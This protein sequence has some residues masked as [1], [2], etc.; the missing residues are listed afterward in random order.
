MLCPA[1]IDRW[2]AEAINTVFAVAI[3]R[4]RGSRTASAAVGQT[5]VFLD[6]DG[7]TAAAAQAA[8]RRTMLD[9]DTHADA[10]AAVGHAAERA[11]TE[12]AAIK[13]RLHQLRDTA[14]GYH[15]S[16]DDRTGV[17]SLP[18][19]L[20]SFSPAA[21]REIAAAQ[22]RLLPAIRQ[23]LC[24]AEQADQD[25]A[26]A[27]RGADGDLAPGKVWAEIC[28]GPFVAP[29]VPTPDAAPEQVNAWWDSLTPSE[30]DRIKHW[31]PDAVRNRDGIPADVRSELNRAALIR[32]LNRLHS[33]WLDRNGWHTE[34]GKLADLIA[35][36]DC[37][38]GQADTDTRLLLLDTGSHPDKV[39][40]AVAVGDVD[41]AERVGVTVAG[42][43]SRVSASVATMVG[44]A[45]NQR[46]AAAQ[47]RRDAALGQPDA[48]AAV[49]YL[50]YDAPD[51]VNEVVRDDLARAGAQPLNRFYRGL[52]AASNVAGAHLTAFGHS[53]GS[54]T[55]SLALQ[56]GAPVGDV[57]LYGSPGAAITDAT[58]LGVPPGHAYYLMAAH[59]VVAD[60]VPLTRRF[61]PGLFDVVGM[62]ALS[63]DGGVAPDGR[64]HERAV[65]HSEYP[66]L[67]G[68]Q[69]LR[70]SGYNMAAVLAGLPDQLV[71]PSP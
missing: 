66:R 58:Q 37:L 26:A 16:I 42:L 8:T 54:L 28:E 7:D 23:L 43:N 25:L 39:L 60:T 41:N 2:S 70:M 18:A 3:Q 53:Y 15:L 19:D 63:T 12:V 69:E 34:P 50:G 33:G 27:I 71:R 67:G 40:A 9:L 1:D 4:A 46:G 47:L 6:W 62:T 59:D 30:Q 64:L 10:C 13:S 35:L 61:G 48:V 65:G 57:V 5:L 11:A 29:V 32:E 22:L 20:A 24:D 21:Q 31:S 44:E 49:A 36:R 38:A 55:T 14:D 56:L 68:N 17:A 51:S 45:H 52:A